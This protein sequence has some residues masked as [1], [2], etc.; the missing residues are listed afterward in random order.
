MFSSDKPISSI[1]EDK[2][3]RKS[4]AKQLAQAIVSY[5]SED[6]FTVELCGKW[7]TGKTSII[8]M[9][10]EEIDYLTKQND[11]KP[12]VVKFNPW[13]Y[14]DKTSLINQFF[15][16][17]LVEI[18]SKASNK[19]L[20]NVGSALQKYSDVLEYSEYIPFVGDYLKPIKKI[21]S[22]VGKNLSEV[23]KNKESLES[24]KNSIINELKKQSQKI[25]VIID[26]IDRLNNEQIRLIFQLVNCV[27]GFPNMIYLLSFDKDVVVRAL[28][29][30]QKCNGEEYLEKIIQVPFDVP[31]AKQ[32]D[33]HKLLFDQ[34]DNLWFDEIPC[35][36]FEKEYWNEVY[37]DCL[38]PFLNTIRDINRVINVYKFKYGLLHDETNCI[39]LLAITTLQICAPKIFDW[40]KDNIDLLTE[41]SHGSGILINDKSKNR[42][43][44]IKKFEKI[45]N[46]PESMLRMLQ[47][48]FPKFSWDTGRYYYD[49]VTEDELRYKQRISCTDRAPLYFRLS[50]EDIGVSK[51]LIVD[52]ITNYDSAELDKM[53]DKLLEKD[54]ISQYAKELNAYAN[55]I[56]N[57]R[58]QLILQKL[59]HLQTMPFD[60]EEKGILY[61][62]PSSYCEDCC[63][64]ILKTTNTDDIVTLLKN[65]IETTNND[66]FDIVANMIVRIERAYG[67]IG[68][69]QDYNYRVISEEQLTSIENLVLERI[70]EI[71]KACFLFKSIS[72]WGKYWFWN[73]KEPTSL[74]NHIHKS[75]NVKNN[76]PYYIFSCAG[77]WTGGKTNGWHFKKESLEEYI[78]VDKVYND[79]ISLKNT[80][81]FSNLEFDV[82]QT[83]VAFYLWYNSDKKEYDSISK[84]N[85]N[86]LIPEWEKTD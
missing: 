68:N 86:S 63:W 35:K 38:C 40:I 70:K 83:A 64:T 21:V 22:S 27:A 51:K 84:E 54:L 67:H 37:N 43:E 11:D 80:E 45:T 81:I 85:V 16:T 29:D 74:Q 3:N 26:D 8:N 28:E 10:V 12:L 69:S 14:S 79:L 23:A 30:E 31:E 2:L 36:N 48:I 65:L 46:D 19:N 82:K 73:Y 9:I 57:D 56:P 4:F 50:L 75:L 78:S 24:L 58:K 55:D 44:L 66:E 49:S 33:V 32:I 17:I 71:S 20:K 42:E 5:T 61:I 62:S 52:S 53:L 18:G 13:N 34:L 15:Q 1:T 39:D 47:V 7:G 77:T 59:I 76:I 25:I 6:N 72:P 41:G 60:D